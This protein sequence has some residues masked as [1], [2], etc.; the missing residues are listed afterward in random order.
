MEVDLKISRCLLTGDRRKSKWRRAG[1]IQNA[2]DTRWRRTGWRNRRWKR[3][4]DEN[5]M[6]YVK[7][8]K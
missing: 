3:N 8:I 6:N 1:V 7:Q 4:S 5:V 2:D